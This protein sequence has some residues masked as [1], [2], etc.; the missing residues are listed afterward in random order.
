MSVAY[1]GTDH[2]QGKYVVAYMKTTPDSGDVYY[3]VAF[4]EHWPGGTYKSALD[5][6]NSPTPAIA[7]QSYK[8]GNGHDNVQRRCQVYRL[9]TGVN[10]QTFFLFFSCICKLERRFLDPY[11]PEYGQFLSP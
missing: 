1:Q 9:R 5:T 10:I 6:E 7:S 8:I 3:V 2:V 11:P 4:S